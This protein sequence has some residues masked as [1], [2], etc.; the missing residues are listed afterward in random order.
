[1]LPHCSRRRRISGTSSSSMAEPMVPLLVRVLA[2]NP[3]TG[4]NILACLTTASAAALRRLHPAVAVVVA[5]VPWADTDTP[6]ADV[7]RWRA[8]L[9]SAVVNWWWPAE[10]A[11]A[12]TLLRAAAALTGMPRLTLSLTRCDDDTSRIAMAILPTSLHTLTVHPHGSSIHLEY[13]TAL[14][15][16]TVSTSIIKV[17]N[18]IL[19][20]SLQQLYARNCAPSSLDGFQNLCALRSLAFTW[21][22]LTIKDFACLPPSLEELELGEA[23][24]PSMIAGF[25]LAHLTRLRVFFAR[26]VAI[27]ATTLASLPPCL[28]TL[29]APWTTKFSATSSFAHLPALRDLNVCG[30][31]I[32]AAS[33]ATLPPSLVSL[34]LASCTKLPATAVLPHLPALRVVDV[35]DTYVGNA[36]VASL[37][38]GLHELYLVD[39]PHVTR[40]ATLD[41]LPALRR[42][43]SSGTDLPPSSLEACRAR[44]CVAPATGVLRG[45]RGIV[46]AMTLLPD[47]RLACGRWGGAVV[48]WDLTCGDAA[49]E[50]LDTCSVTIMAALPDGLLAVGRDHSIKVWDVTSVPAVLRATVGCCEKVC[51]LAVLHD[52]RLAAGCSKGKI[53]VVDVQRRVVVGAMKGHTDKVNAMAVMPEG[54]LASGS[55]DTNVRVWNTGTRECVAMML[56]HTSGVTMLVALAGGQLA[57][58]LE[59][60][61]ILWDVDERTTVVI[62]APKTDTHDLAALAPLPDGRLAA[63]F[64]KDGIWVWDTRSDTMSAGTHAA[65]VVPTVLLGRHDTSMLIAL[66]DGRLASTDFGERDP[67]RAPNIGVRLW[68]HPPPA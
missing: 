22:L 20:P 28:E 43:N 36:L 24:L 21:G 5:K 19:P 38:A 48:A 35:S 14:V 49:K 67:D 12:I 56:G 23:Y 68:T 3:V 44:G 10:H 11:D 8:A 13:L 55:D 47:G 64:R 7:V 61:V 52:G 33:L 40:A 31:G 62:R 6:T 39:C 4:A 46:T 17:V 2:G 42:L 53:L 26:M 51:A 59:R 58:A 34:G 54:R 37:P 63:C 16:L 25:S 27:D 9:P 66:P 32:G 29:S 30:S 18:F 41:H 57:F 50:V 15:S 65:G 1:M 45:P 60:T